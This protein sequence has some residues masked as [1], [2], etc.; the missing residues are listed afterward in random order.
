MDVLETERLRLRPWRP[1]DAPR[2]AEMMADPVCA[3]FTTPDGKPLNVNAAWRTMATI[4]GHGV[5]RGYT[6]FAVEEKVSGLWVGRIGPWR[7]EGWPGLEL[8]WALHPDARGKGYATEGARAALDWMFRVLKPAEVISVIAPGNTASIAV[9]ER[10]GERFS[11][12]WRHPLAGETHLYAVRD[13]NP[14]R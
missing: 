5:L 7:P 2:H 4:A 11:R 12:T 10:I 3:R 8:G 6:M 14:V 1:E 13:K 9:A